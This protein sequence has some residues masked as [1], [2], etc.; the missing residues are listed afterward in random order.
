MKRHAWPYAMVALLLGALINS[1]AQAD[2]VVVIVNK[3]NTNPIDHALVI[4][5]YTGATRGWPDGTPIFALDQDDDSPIRADFYANVLGKSRAIVKAIWAQNI[6]AGKG[7]PPKIANPDAE[8][9]KL[10]SSNKSSIGYIRASSVDDSVKVA[11][12]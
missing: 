10:V 5:I 3:G 8:M 7:L 4:K 1:P 11:G 2:D 6:F 12:Q 9:K